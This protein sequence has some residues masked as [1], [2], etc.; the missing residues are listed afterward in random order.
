V[1]KGN[2]FP[3]KVTV[4]CGKT[5]YFRDKGFW[6]A[7]VLCETN[8]GGVKKPQLRLYGWQWSKKKSKWY[9]A[10][11]FNI[12]A[13]R[14]LPDIIDYIHI[15]AQESG[16]DV[17]VK[18]IDEKLLSRIGELERI[19]NSLEKQKSKIPEL[20]KNLKEFEKLLDNKKINEQKIHAFLKKNT[21][22][23]GTNYVRM[24]KSEKPIIIKSRC[25][26]LLQKSDKYFDIIELKSPKHPLFCNVR[27]KKKAMSKELKDA[28]SQVMLYLAEARTYYLSIKDQ[29]GFDI[30]FPQ[31]IIVIGRRKKE[32]KQIMQI[33]KEFLNKINILTYDDLL[34]NAKE[35][36]KTYQKKK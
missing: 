12:S 18:K 1:E 34:D 6:K 33:H 24:H 2:I 35:T 4:L 14:Y 32:D 13:A 21:W 8:F 22:I 5:L 27:G 3:A 10:Q 23:L 25:D 29:T 26:F 15:F 20:K 9:Q 31:G 16:K 19:N 7:V 30:Y 11:K 36:I 17:I 28:I